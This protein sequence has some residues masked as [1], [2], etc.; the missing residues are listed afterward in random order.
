MV[1][2]SVM[3][4]TTLTS[5]FL[6][7]LKGQVDD[8]AISFAGAIQYNDSCANNIMVVHPLVFKSSHLKPEISTSLWH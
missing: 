1:D 6:V 2:L 8:T 7:A 4:F 3:S 5:N